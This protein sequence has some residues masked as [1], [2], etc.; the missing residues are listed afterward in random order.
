MPADAGS[1]TT[2]G[3]MLDAIASMEIGRA[4]VQACGAFIAD[5]I[6]CMAGGQAAEA[7]QPA[8]RWGAKQSPSARTSALV[9]AA[10][11]NALEMDAMH[12]ASSVHPGT[13][14]VP[15][16]LAVAN[17]VDVD[18]AALARA[19]L[20]G[21]EAAIR[22][23]RATGALHGQRFQSTSTCAGFGAALACADLLGLSQTQ[24]LDAMSQMA[25]V[26]GGLWAFIEEDTLTKQ[27]HAARAAEGA[28]LAAELAAEGLRGPRRIL[29]G[30]RGFLAILC[31]GGDPAQLV[32][33]GT[34][35]QLHD[36]AFKPWPSPRP[37]HAAI[38]AALR[39]R[40]AIGDATI[41]RAV[42]HTYGMAIALCNRQTLDSAHDAR[43]SLR[44][45]VAVA[46][47]N[48][49]V[50]LA[51]FEP[52]QRA[53]QADLAARIEVREDPAMTSDYPG[54]SR[55]R[56]DVKLVSGAGVI[57]EAAHALGDPELPLSEL[58]RRQKLRELLEAGAVHPDD[59]LLDELA[60][61]AS[62]TTNLA[63][64]LARVLPRASPGFTRATQP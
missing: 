35:W 21:S 12:V 17:A 25:S 7:A 3:T 5:A 2:M 18:G 40:S 36:I 51:S 9:M 23:G 16:A 45:C 22:L 43:F 58:Q 44:Y 52:A 19:V 48:G 62:R 11:S 31:D 1:G 29:E 14:V 39:A 26:A 47:R 20:R 15:A 63:P 13:V 4:D 55:A 27:W 33:P 10:L 56:I 60:D 38:T 6:G 53:R 64:L 49:T 37:T 50:D 30:K 28:V 32:A 8:L 24:T 61:I 41:E 46:L 34:R 54:R 59:G 42:L 57:A